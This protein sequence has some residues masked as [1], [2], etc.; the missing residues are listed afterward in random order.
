MR[1]HCAFIEA[2]LDLS[3]LNSI[4]VIV[5]RMQLPVTLV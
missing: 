1:V 5:M 4:D 2:R 3:A